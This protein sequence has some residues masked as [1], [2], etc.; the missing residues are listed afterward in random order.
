MPFLDTWD[1]RYTNRTDRPQPTSQAVMFCLMDVSG[2]MDEERK[3]IAKRFF[4][5]L[6]LFLTRSY[7]RIDL[8]FIRHHTVAKEVDEED[9]FASRETG[10]TVVSSAL[11]LM[12]EIVRDRYP[13]NQWNIYA[14][15]ASDGDNWE[16]DSPRCRDLLV[17]S[18]LPLVQYYAYVE[19]KA[20]RPQSL[21]REYEYVKSVSR[22]FAMRRILTL[23]DIYPVF[24]DLFRKKEKA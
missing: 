8:V 1:L 5:L 15:Q 10:G 2:S 23:E 20:E 16:E 3:N 14:A 6:Y 19:I 9:F 7:E 11:E 18:I 13:S 22:R 4:M 12:H 17:N 21:W 24:R